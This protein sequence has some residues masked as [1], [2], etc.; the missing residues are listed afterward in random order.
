M[1]LLVGGQR[2]GELLGAVAVVG[3]ALCYAFSVLYAGLT[4]RSLPPLQVSIGQFLTG[5][6]VLVPFTLV[7]RPADVPSW[8]AVLAVGALGVLGTGVAY[9]IYFELIATAGAARAILVT[10]LVPAFAVVYGALFLDEPLELAAVL[11]LGLVLGGTALGTGLVR[12]RRPVT[13]GTT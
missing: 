13:V 8:D 5:A 3:V 10:Y 2:G 7:Q 12:G 11:G 4:V 1:A 9:L 6:V